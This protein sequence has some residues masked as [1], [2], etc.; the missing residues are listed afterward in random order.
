MVK[1]EALCGF[2]YGVAKDGPDA[3]LLSCAKGS[4]NS[5]LEQTGPDA[6]PF[7]RMV[8]S[9]SA[10]NDYRDRIGNIASESARDLVMGH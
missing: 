10:Q 5:I 4:C 9:Q 7:V 3:D 8:H 1:V 2:I 6:L